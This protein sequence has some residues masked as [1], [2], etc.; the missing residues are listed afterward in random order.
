M[1]VEPELSGFLAKKCSSVNKTVFCLSTRTFEDFLINFFCRLWS[2]SKGFS[3]FSGNDFSRVLKT[4]FHSSRRTFD[5]ER[6]F[7]N[8]CF[9]FQAFR[10]GAQT[11][12]LLLEGLRARCRNCVLCIQK[13]VLTKTF[14]EL[15]FFWLFLGA[16]ANFFWLS[17]RLFPA[18]LSKLELICPGEHFKG[19]LNS[20]KNVIFFCSPISSEKIRQCCR[21]CNHRVQRKFP[22]IFWKTVMVSIFSAIQQFF[23]GVLPKIFLQDCQDCCSCVQRIFTG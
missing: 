10:F 6:F 4:K 1:D 15:A 13:E 17:E 8:C 21:N 14:S 5:V 22:K 9:P 7:S 16:C 20:R 19:S 3:E 23:S 12:G 2:L 18:G 11:F